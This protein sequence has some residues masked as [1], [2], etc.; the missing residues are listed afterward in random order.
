[1]TTL[2]QNMGIR[3]LEIHFIPAAQN[4]LPRDPTMTTID[5][6]GAS[7]FANFCHPRDFANPHILIKCTWRGPKDFNSQFFAL[8]WRT[9]NWIGLLVW[10]GLPIPASAVCLGCQCHPFLSSKFAL[11]L[12]ARNLERMGTRESAIPIRPQKCAEVECIC[13]NGERIEKRGFWMGGWGQQAGKMRWRG[14]GPSS[15][16]ALL[17]AQTAQLSKYAVVAT[18]RISAH[19]MPALT[20]LR[21]ISLVKLVGICINF[22]H[23][24][25]KNECLSKFM[26]CSF[27]QKVAH[28]C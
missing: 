25:P 13:W 16:S 2:N 27:D 21:Q 8:F 18:T 23:G 4:C 17:S 15:C 3:F 14:F 22:C 28:Y 6:A 1:M 12:R 11:H 24:Y 20:S 7:S 26:F 9:P 5:R 19:Q 10:F